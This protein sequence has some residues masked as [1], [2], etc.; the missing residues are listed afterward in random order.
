M[1]KQVLSKLASEPKPE[2]TQPEVKS[3]KRETCKGFASPETKR[4]FLAN[5]TRFPNDREW[6]DMTPIERASFIMD[7]D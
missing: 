5:P 1:P 7:L 4:E 6:E 3:G 2:Q